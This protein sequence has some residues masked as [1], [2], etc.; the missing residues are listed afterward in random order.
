MIVSSKVLII[1]H[2]QSAEERAEK[3]K[4]K[5]QENKS[6]VM[7]ANDQLDDPENFNHRWKKTSTTLLNQRRTVRSLGIKLNTHV[8]GESVTRSP[9]GSNATSRNSS[10]NDDSAGYDNASKKS[11]RFEQVVGKKVGGKPTGKVK[12]SSLPRLQQVADM[13][14]KGHHARGDG[15][16]T[17][18][19]EEE[20]DWGSLTEHKD[21]I[22]Q[23]VKQRLGK[24]VEILVRKLAELQYEDDQKRSEEELKSALE[25][26]SKA[27]QRTESIS[28]VAAELKKRLYAERA[29]RNTEILPEAQLTLPAPHPGPLP[30]IG[31]YSSAPHVDE[32]AH[33]REEFNNQHDNILQELEKEREE[34]RKAEDILS[35]QQQLIEELKENMREQMEYILEEQSRRYDELKELIQR[36][37]SQEHKRSIRP[38]PSDQAYV[39]LDGSS[40]SG[41][42]GRDAL[43]DNRDSDEENILRDQNAPRQ[44]PE[45]RHPA[46]RIRQGGKYWDSGDPNSPSSTP[47][48][49]IQ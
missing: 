31:E 1:F 34:R 47:H 24:D 45:R 48:F 19:E 29:F 35:D 25:R 43:E 4:E 13:K 41:S 8:T 22:Q 21:V 38:S 49:Y 20:S 18:V 46:E 44:R 2:L 5:E 26:A 23:R 12:D 14:L 6:K 10:R 36:N 33:A 3:R 32:T 42:H 28:S 17:D 39:S 40:H 9:L 7:T 15:S 11:S 27:R 37:T 16:T 30:S